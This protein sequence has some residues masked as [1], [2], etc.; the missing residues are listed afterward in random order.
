MSSRQLARGAQLRRFDGAVLRS[1]FDDDEFVI[2]TPVSTTRMSFATVRSIAV[3][4]DFVVVRYHGNP[5]TS[6]YARALFPDEHV[7]A[8][9]ASSRAPSHP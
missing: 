1:G 5:I 7:A 6:I 2:T 9:R 8:I 4:G 3:H